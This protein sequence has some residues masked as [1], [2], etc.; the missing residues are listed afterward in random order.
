MRS[1]PDGIAGDFRPG[2]K[3]AAIEEELAQH[4]RLFFHIPHGQLE[5]GGISFCGKLP[6]LLDLEY[7]AVNGLHCADD[8]GRTF[9]LA[10]GNI[11]QF[12][13]VFRRING[14]IA[15]FL[16]QFNGGSPF[17]IEKFLH[18]DRRYISCHRIDMIDH[19]VIFNDKRRNVSHFCGY[20]R[21]CL[22]NGESSLRSSFFL[23]RS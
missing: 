23:R 4:Q 21:N 22:L 8:I 1:N 10:D 16:C 6:T 13:T 20:S 11:Q 9:S 7:F 2:G 15:V 14:E 17:G 3:I 18:R 12:P 19:I 5:I